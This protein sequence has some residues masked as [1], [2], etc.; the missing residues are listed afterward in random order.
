[1]GLSPAV[2]FIGTTKGCIV[3]LAKIGGAWIDPDHVN[4]VY[5]DASQGRTAVMV[6]VS[7]HPVEVDHLP[8]YCDPEDEDTALETIL[9]AVADASRGEPS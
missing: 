9:A 1:M 5:L 2:A 8:L 3:S 7:G 4:A 6:V